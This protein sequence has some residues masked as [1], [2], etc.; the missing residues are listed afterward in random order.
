MAG[1]DHKCPYCNAEID[2]EHAW[3]ANDQ[4]MNFRTV[5]ESCRK[6]VEIDV[7]TEPVFETSK[8]RCLMC[9]KAEPAGSPWYCGEC[10]KKL[11]ELS[12]RNGEKIKSSRTIWL[13]R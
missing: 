11:Q 4:R 6:S 13:E 10:H 3:R 5:C 9:H 12:K 2:V 1:F 8:P 7:H